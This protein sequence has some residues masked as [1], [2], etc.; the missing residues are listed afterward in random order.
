M[1]AA[2]MIQ[3]LFQQVFDAFDGFDGV[4]AVAE[5]GQTE[6]AFA[7]LAEALAGGADD[8]S[9]PEQVVEELPAAHAVRALEP[10]VGGILAAGVVDAELVERGGD[11]AGVLFVVVQAF[12]DLG[13]T[14]VGEYRGGG[15]LD[16]V[17]DAV[18]LGRL[19]A[20]PQVVDVVTVADQ[21]F[22]NHGITAARA[23]KA[24]GLRERAELD[25]TGA[26]AVDREDRAGAIVGDERFVCRVVEDDRVVF[27]G[28]VDPRFQLIGVI[29]RAGG[30]VRGAKV[31]DVCLDVI[32]GH[33]KEAVF[34]GA[35]SVDD[36]SARHDVGVDVD[37]IDRVGDHDDVIC[38]EDIA[39]VAGV[40]LSAVGDE[41][42]VG[43]DG[44]AVSLI[45]AGDRLA[46]EVVALILGVA[47]EGFLYAQLVRA[48]FQ[49]VDDHGR[50]RQGD[51]ADAELDDPF[52]GVRLD[53]GV[54]AGG[55]L[56]K[57]V[58]WNKIVV[59]LID[60]HIFTFHRIF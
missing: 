38:A 46:R 8:L 55:Y 18:E 42:L 54:G 34:A 15:A 57:E 47:L 14:F 7:A 2:W 44:H 50:K 6:V 17:A 24:R 52:V 59:I 49:R 40:G 41:N 3:R 36:L 60:F 13:E 16:G 25:R 10:D 4:V 58:A 37:G 21:L 31:D 9:V 20:I 12:A 23:G 11:D 30:V 56:G 53:I 22:R 33:G 19:A 27:V 48:F 35:G 43:G 51:V 1:T 26:R 29:S 28:V 5:G 45:I 39:D 32:V